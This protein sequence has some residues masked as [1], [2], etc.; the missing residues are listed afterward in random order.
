ML[1]NWCKKGEESAIKGETHSI[2]PKFW[3]GM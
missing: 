2:R 3:T 1:V